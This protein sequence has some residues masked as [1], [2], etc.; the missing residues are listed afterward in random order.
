MQNG[1]QAYDRLWGSILDDVKLQMTNATF[2]TWVQDTR[3]IKADPQHGQFV[4]ATQNNF[5]LEW[6]EHRLFGT[7]EEAIR[8]NLGRDCL[9]EIELT[10]VVESSSTQEQPEQSAPAPAGLKPVGMESLEEDALAHD[11]ELVNFSPTKGNWVQTGAYVLFFWQPYLGKG[12]FNIWQTLLAFAR[13]RKVP[14]IQ[15]LADICASGTRQ[16]ITG[17]WRRRKKQGEVVDKYWQTGW[18][19]KLEEEKIVWYKQKEDTE[20]YVFRVL[21]DLPLLTPSQ[22]GQLPSR[23]QN[24]HEEWLT[25]TKVDYEEW[26]K[27]T[28]PTLTDLR[29]KGI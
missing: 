1:A 19:E 15:K 5:A 23:L 9:D 11:I 29:E 8:H 6:L 12:P 7:I 26:Q 24:I 22:V 13:I 2:E 18:I 4:V 25:T 21:E 20:L 27:V 16:T 28:A 10:F 17:R 3:L 14:S